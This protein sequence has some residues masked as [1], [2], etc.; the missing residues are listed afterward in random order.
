MCGCGREVFSDARKLAWL[1]QVGRFQ[2]R[3]T[4]NK[5]FGNVLLGDFC[6]KEPCPQS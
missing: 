4:G 3:K 1:A 5:F 2:K 6:S